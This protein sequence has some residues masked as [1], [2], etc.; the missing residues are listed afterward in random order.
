MKKLL[1]VACFILCALLFGIVVSAHSGKTDSYGGHYDSSSGEYHYHHGYSAHS[2]YDM[3]GDGYID[4][5]F[6][7]DDKTNHNSSYNNDFDDKTNH[8][9]SFNNNYSNADSEIE[10]DFEPSNS[11]TLGDIIVMLLKIIVISF[12]ILLVG[13]VVWVLVY[14]CLTFLL[15]WICEK[16][17]KIDANKSVIG[18]ISI[19]AIVVVVIIIASNIALN[20]EELF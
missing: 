20:S 16:I 18:K 5:P 10:A 14:A 1:V 8:S 7:F 2:H 11:L 4:C 17:F 9:N 3:D 15:S 19:I 6:D 12:M 13:F